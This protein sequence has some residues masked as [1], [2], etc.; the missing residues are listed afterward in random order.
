MVVAIY[1]KNPPNIQSDAPK[2]IGIPPESFRCHKYLKALERTM[3]GRGDLIP[4][5]GVFGIKALASSGS[6]GYWVVN[7]KE[8]GGKVTYMGNESPDVVFAG[9]DDDLADVMAGE[10]DPQSAFYQGKL[11]VQGK[12]ALALNLQKSLAGRI[13]AKI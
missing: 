12:V 4:V 10:L 8:D 2:V 7:T 11:K 5:Q 9:K 1:R 6:V 3:R 13:R